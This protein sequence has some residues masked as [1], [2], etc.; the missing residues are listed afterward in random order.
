MADDHQR[1]QERRG[2]PGEETDGG[3][4][5]GFLLLARLRDRRRRSERK[6]A[7]AFQSVGTQSSERR[8][9]GF[10][11]AGATVL[12]FDQYQ[13]LTPALSTSNGGI[14]MSD[15]EMTIRETAQAEI[16][17]HLV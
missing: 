2:L 4:P 14:C 5:E 9:L 8:W 11:R 12:H 16:S 1:A 6:P 3:Q 7:Q 17:G 15:N 10:R 13:R